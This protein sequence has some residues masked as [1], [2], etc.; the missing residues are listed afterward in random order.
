MAAESSD[1]LAGRPG[2]RW[3]NMTGDIWYQLVSSLRKPCAVC[4]RRHAR[5]RRGPGGSR[6]TRIASASS[7][8]SRPVPGPRS[9]SATPAGWPRR[10]RS[11]ARSSW[12]GALNWLIRSAGLVSWDDL[13]DGDGDPREFDDVVRRKGLTVEQLRRAGVAEG[14]ARRAVGPPG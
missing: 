4:L 13:F 9:S 10:C 6:S 12:S 8:R 11:A 2:E 1:G 14:V 7:S 5:S 3:R